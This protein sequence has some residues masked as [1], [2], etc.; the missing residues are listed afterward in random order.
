MHCQ[1]RTKLPESKA[2]PGNED[3]NWTKT[4]KRP[5]G[6]KSTTEAGQ[7]ELSAKYHQNIFSE[8]E[9]DYPRTGFGQKCTAKSG[10]SYQKARLGQETRTEAG[11]DPDAKC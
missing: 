1:I 3:G 2:C 4:V 7:K 9:Q 6:Q 11:Q 10:Q 8:I 5:S